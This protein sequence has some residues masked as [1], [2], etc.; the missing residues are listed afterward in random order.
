MRF[1]CLLA[2][3]VLIS[4]AGW[5]ALSPCITDPPTSKPA[6]PGRLTPVADH[7]QHL[8]GP[9]ALPPSPPM[10]PVVEVPADLEQLLEARAKLYAHAQKPEDV[11]KVFTPEAMAITWGKPTRWVRGETA[12]AEGLNGVIDQEYRFEPIAFA[13]DGPSGYIAGYV[14]V[15]QG[16]VAHPALD[17]L[18]GIVR[19][20]DG[21]WRVAA[22]NVTI[23]T[24]PT[25]TKPIP[26]EKLIADLDEAGI[27]RALAISAAFWLDNGRFPDPADE[28]TKEY[29]AVRAENDWT[30][31]E[32][33]KYPGRLFMA[34]SVNPLRA[35]ALEELER[36]SRIRQ[37][38]AFKVH[39]ASCGIDLTN[40]EHQ[41]KLRAFFARANELRMPLIV[42]LKPRMAYGP[43]EVEWF[44]QEL[45]AGAA[46]DIAVQI[47]HMAGDGPSI[48]APEALAGFAG[49]C[50]K[51]DP[52]TRNLF[53]DFGGLV[54]RETSREQTHLMAERMR[55]IGFDKI[56]YG[57]DGQPPN[58][59]TA[60]HWLQTWGKLPLS[61]DEFSKI[62]VNVAP[63]LQR[64]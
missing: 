41:E 47:A 22:E 46:P 40:V 13:T 5:I 12:L 16:E 61:E 4:F 64:R 57:S 8:L 2:T 14:S 48:D 7:H 51:G 34:A 49:A 20:D 1:R 28:M 21:Q 18:L 6:G 56:V 30:A 31:A 52:R 33:A 38:R 27:Q 45:I 29:D 39:I 25:Y 17:F 63:Y 60:E 55:Q 43:A 44:L 3:P 9:A 23:K 10:L 53:F 54:T 26:A 62:A 36:C 37:V 11:L 24:P 59:P 32:V 35:Y 15:V 19:G 42:H 58:H 50:A